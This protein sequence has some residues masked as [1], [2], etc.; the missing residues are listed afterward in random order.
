MMLKNIIVWFGLLFFSLGQVIAQNDLSVFNTKFGKQTTDTFREKL[1]VHTDQDFY[2]AGEII[3]FKVYLS[4]ASTHILTD[5][6]SVAYVEILD[7]D[8]K[9]VLQL[10]VAIENGVGNGSIFLPV[11]L[12]S[13]NF[14][15]RAYTN[16][17][18]NFAPDDNFEKTITIFNSLKASEIKDTVKSK[19][20]DIQFFPEGGNLLEGVDCKVAFKAVDGYGKGVNFTGKLL[21][22]LNQEVAVF[23]PLKFGI[24]NF[25]FKPEKDVQYK[26]VINYNNQKLVKDLMPAESNAYA[27]QL[28]EIG[29]DSVKITI[30][31]RADNDSSIYLL[32]HQQD[33]TT[34]LQEVKMKSGT[35]QV[36]IDKQK[37]GEGISSFTIFDSDIQPVCERLYF[38]RPTK[39]LELSVKTNQQKYLSREKVS[40][41]IQSR[42]EKAN[43]LASNLSLSIFLTDSLQKMNEANIFSY[44]WLKSEI[45]GKIENVNY[46]FE[47]DD[48]ETNLALDNL[49]LT[50]GWR[51][52][53]GKEALKVEKPFLK[54]KPEYQQNIINGR[55]FYKNSDKP[56]PDILTSLSVVG[57]TEHL[58]GAKSDRDGYLAFNTKNI[59]GPVQLALQTY[60]LE[61][62]LYKLELDDPFLKQN[63]DEQLPQL[64]LSKYFSK[65]VLD[66][67][68]YMQVQNVYN[69]DK[70]KTFITK[71]SKEV[72]FYGNA[73]DKNYIL[74]QYVRFPT[75]EEIFREYVPE[76]VVEKR[77]KK[78]S[79]TTY[80]V[81]DKIYLDSAPLVLLDGILVK[82]MNR[83]MAY[84]PLKINELD[85]VAK[86]YYLGPLIFGG[87]LNFSSIKGDFKDFN[88]DPN[89]VLVDYEGLQVQRKFYTPVYANP[90]EK[91][92]RLP[93]FRTLLYWSGDVKTS[94]TG[95]KNI[96]FYTSDLKG[97]YIIVLQGLSDNG[98]LGY[99]TY[100]FKVE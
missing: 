53:K 20:F 64:Q 77:D 97:S 39:K 100:S 26:A 65:S 11:S 72:S 75:L 60:N 45:K 80:N 19:D 91:A 37:L 10:K 89:V 21:N 49:L 62:S 87:I 14:K 3:W 9:P 17:M 6:S 36:Y 29:S 27:M 52:F 48:K 12:P 76:V 98:R 84:D 67:S 86:K 43:N 24:G 8:Q 47:N 30:T 32:V 22:N 74:N 16:W 25:H 23:E 58:Y 78:F 79:L 93:D 31:H 1:F 85:I 82:D 55:V 94:L 50:Q 51:K 68:I 56:A 92:S 73:S 99:S 42:D 96:D 18:K 88:L 66:R 38:K 13:G 54:F 70:L 71:S 33:K 83:L 2:L 15:L 41:Q 90:K 40:L 69:A 28:N 34:A 46:Y 4:D 35:A 95:T 57:S 59:F 61:D 7:V 81:Q 44:L 5:L 63:S